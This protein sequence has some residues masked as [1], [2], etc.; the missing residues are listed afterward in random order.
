[1]PE[2]ND[3]YATT[4]VYK[5]VMA[6]QRAYATAVRGLAEEIARRSGAAPDY[7]GIAAHFKTLHQGS[8]WGWHR[9]VSVCWALLTVEGSLSWKQA[10][11]LA[12]T[13]A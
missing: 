10:Q 1:M 13:V 8:T 11:S 3:L 4:D 5:H 2:G 9:C 12:R 6:E 7:E